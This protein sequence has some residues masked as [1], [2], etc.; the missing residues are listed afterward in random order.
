MATSPPVPAARP[1]P[2]AAPPVR[3]PAASYR[4]RSRRQDV[5]DPLAWDAAPDVDRRQRPGLLERRFHD[6]SAAA[7]PFPD[8]DLTRSRYEEV[9]LRLAGGTPVRVD[10]GLYRP[11]RM[12]GWSH[13][14]FVRAD[15]GEERQ[16]SIDELR[17][18]G[19]VWM[20]ARVV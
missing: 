12:R 3:L 5:P 8:R 6:T 1:V 10:G 9:F 18:D 20:D 11:T 14:V 15:T 2:P 7:A 4:G 16:F 17:A 19:V 13:A